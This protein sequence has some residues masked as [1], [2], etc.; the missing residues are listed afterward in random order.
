MFHMVGITPEA[1][2]IE[3]AFQGGKI[4]ER[5][6]FGK[7]ELEKVYEEL[8]EA[9]GDDIDFVYIGCPH[10]TLQEMAE[11]AV[12]LRDRRIAEGVT[13][14]LT[15]PYALMMQGRRLGFVQTIERA[16]GYVMVDTC[17]AVTIWPRKKRM[18]TNS[19][20]QAY[21]S[22]GSLVGESILTSTENCLRIATIG[23]R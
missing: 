12:Y 21:Y 13:F 1:P 2:T 15:T 6:S 23:R 7:K 20:K 5:Y 18:A 8:S 3:A 17:P 9:T 16:G 19:V 11:V 4:E 10:C 14:I 22:R